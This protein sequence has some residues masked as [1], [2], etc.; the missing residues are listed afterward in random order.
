MVI[1]GEICMAPSFRR[2]SFFASLP[3]GEA[4]ALL[5]GHAS[6]PGRHT[7]ERGTGKKNKQRKK[8]KKGAE[9]GESREPRYDTAFLPAAWEQLGS[10]GSRA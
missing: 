2:A 7:G 5:P 9:N 4:S 10:P 1:S 3:T 8:G 6:G